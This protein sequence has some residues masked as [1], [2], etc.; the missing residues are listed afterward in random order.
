MIDETINKLNA[1]G[2]KDIVVSLETQFFDSDSGQ[3]AYE[4]LHAD[5]WE[6]V[7][8]KR[9]PS[10]GIGKIEAIKIAKIESEPEI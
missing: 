5:R 4:I 2:L 7:H 1:V 9:D 6:V 3:K 8:I 10:T